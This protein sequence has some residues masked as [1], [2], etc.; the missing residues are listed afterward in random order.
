MSKV[1][2]HDRRELR[3]QH[4]RDVVCVDMA[5]TLT[6]RELDSSLAYHER[7]DP[8]SPQLCEMKY[9]P[10]AMVDPHAHSEDEIM[11]LLEGSIHIGARTIESG[12]SV[13]IAAATLYGFSTGADGARMLVFRPRGGARFVAK[14]EFL[15]ERERAPARY[16]F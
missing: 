10:N 11:Y 16:K 6:D 13:F 14:D 4:M 1:R 8:H 7:G 3:W 2:I 5:R 9:L 15:R 12:T